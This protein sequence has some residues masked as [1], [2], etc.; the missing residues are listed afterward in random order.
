MLFTSHHRHE[1]DGE[2]AAVASR[3]ETS[4]RQEPNLLVEAR[5]ELASITHFEG[6]EDSL[7]P[8]FLK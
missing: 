6:E 8:H 7:S 2:E 3:Q 4:I 1:I 5:K